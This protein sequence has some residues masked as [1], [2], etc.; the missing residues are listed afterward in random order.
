MGVAARAPL[1][2]A[3]A[4][5]AQELFEAHKLTLYRYLKRVLVSREDA[6]EILQ[7]TY[8]RFLRQPSFDRL[9][10]NA[11]AYLF[12]TATNLAYDFFRQRSLKSIETEADLFNASGMGSPRWSSWPELALQGE[13]TRAIIMQALADLPV[14]VRTALLQ[15]RFQELTHRE[16]ARRIGV[17]E[18]TVER[19]IKDGL[20]QIAARLGARP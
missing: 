2:P 11:R 12:Q 15:H 14:A 10:H 9:R 4:Q 5:F 17:S 19:Y 8:L 1:S 3:E 6:Q 18:R 7:E 20:S 13:Q 16:I